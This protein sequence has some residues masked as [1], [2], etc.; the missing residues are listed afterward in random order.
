MLFDFGISKLISKG[1]IGGVE[2]GKHTGMC[3]S[4]RYMAPEVAMS[5]PYNDRSEI[6]SMSLI[7]WE[8]LTHQ[9]VY[10]NVEA[11]TFEQ[12]VCLDH[13]RPT[14]PD[15]MPDEAKQVS[16]PFVFAHPPISPIWHTPLFP[17]LTV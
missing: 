1:E 6:Y 17:Y 2:G 7:L 16:T 8:M 5:K 11:H 14:L 3:G 9:P 15:E 13:V 12:M 10:A 4:L